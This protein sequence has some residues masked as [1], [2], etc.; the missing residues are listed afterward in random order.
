MTS[1]MYKGGWLRMNWEGEVMRMLVA[2]GVMHCKVGDGWPVQLE[3]H[4]REI[5]C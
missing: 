4:W 2:V 1:R 5:L 3:V